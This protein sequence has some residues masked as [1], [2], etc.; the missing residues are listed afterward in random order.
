MIQMYRNLHPEDTETTEDDL[1][2]MTVDNVLSIKH[3]NDLGVYI[4]RRTGSLMILAEAQSHWSINVL[5]RL[6]EYVVDAL[7]NYFINNGYDLYGT[8]KLAV[9][10]IEA[11]IVY[12]GKSVPRIFSEGRLRTDDNI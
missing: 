2:I 9:P 1:T 8:T 12:S 7:M 6:W 5:F 11:Y 3:Y 4:S 10:D